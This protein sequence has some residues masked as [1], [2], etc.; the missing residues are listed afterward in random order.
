MVGW[1]KKSLLSLLALLALVLA[2]HGVALWQIGQQL[3]A[4]GSA[5]TAQTDPLFTRQI[6]QQTV[7]TTAAATPPAPV[8]KFE[9]KRPV[10]QVNAAQAATKSIVDKTTVEPTATLPVPTASA[11][12]TVDS[13]V[14]DTV[15][16]L[17]DVTVNASDTSPLRSPQAEASAASAA[18]GTDPAASLAAQGPWPSDTLLSY[19]LG[20]YFRGELFGNAQVQWTRLP[21]VQS[22]PVQ[23]NP[24]QSTPTSVATPGERYQVRINLGIGPLGVQFASQGRI[25]ITG[26]QPEVYEEQVPNGTRKVTLERREIVLNNGS[27]VPRPEDGLA[28]VQDTASQFVELGQRFSTGR[29]RL[30]AGEVVR[31]WLARPGG[32]DE[33]V[34]DIGPAETLTLPSLGAVQAYPLTPRPLANPRG[35]ISAQMWI[36]PSLQNLLVRIKIT[37]SE[38]SYVDLVVQKIEQR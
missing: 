30:A 4:M 17:L 18:E 2:L 23:S 10:A 12:V 33:W 26:L 25:G 36:A 31:L 20:G 29:A 22:N 5:I 32:V 6:T 28:N 16:K 15:S 1:L 13:V 35:T 27:R 21:Y 34:Y 38:Q 8:P 24:V 14:Q 7:L 3:R 9:P 11:V 19:K 37:L